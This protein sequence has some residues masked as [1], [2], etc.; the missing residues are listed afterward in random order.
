VGGTQMV[1]QLLAVLQEHLPGV[2]VGAD[3]L[4]HPQARIGRMVKDSQRELLQQVWGMALSPGTC[5]LPVVS[6]VRG[7]G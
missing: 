4:D 2:Q 6:P 7:A 5:A 3:R 1:D